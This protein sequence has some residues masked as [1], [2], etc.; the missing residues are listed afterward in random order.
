LVISLW[1]YWKVDWKEMGPGRRSQAI[2]GVTLKRVLTHTPFSLSLLLGH[3]EASNYDILSY[4]RPQNSG[5]N[6]PCTEASESLSQN[7]TLP[8][9]KLIF[10]G[11]FSQ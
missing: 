1:Q 4:H 10:S 7:K 2:E 9:F 11:I 8:P 3:H 6:G 5:A